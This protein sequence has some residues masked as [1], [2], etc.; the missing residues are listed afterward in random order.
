M[1]YKCEEL[2]KYITFV[3]AWFS[4]KTWEFLN[5]DDEKGML[6]KKVKSN[7]NLNEEIEEDVDEEGNEE[8]EENEIK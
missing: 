4:E 6:Q 8:E 7:R 1:L 2:N 5:K 3:D